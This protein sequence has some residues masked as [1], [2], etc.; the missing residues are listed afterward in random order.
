MKKKY[1]NPEME[2]IEIKTTCMLA[3][4]LPKSDSPTI[5]NAGDILAPEQ[6]EDFLFDF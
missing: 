4:S 3:A 5:D 2:V 1:I 6:S